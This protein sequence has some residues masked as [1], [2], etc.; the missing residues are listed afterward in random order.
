MASL[1]SEMLARRSPISSWYPPRQPAA[2]PIGSLSQDAVANQAQGP[3]LECHADKQR[4]GTLKTRRMSAPS[5]DVLLVQCHDDKSLV[6]RFAS[7]NII[8]ALGRLAGGHKKNCKYILDTEAA[9]RKERAC[10]IIA[11]LVFTVQRKAFYDPSFSF[12]ESVVMAMIYLDTLSQHLRKYEVGRSRWLCTTSLRVPT[13]N[14]FSANMSRETGMH[15]ISGKVKLPHSRLK[16]T[17]TVVEYPIDGWESYLT[18]RA[19]LQHSQ[20][21]SGETGG[22]NNPLPRGVMSS[23]SAYPHKG[24]W[25]VVNHWLRVLQDKSDYQRLT[26]GSESP[27]HVRLPEVNHW[28][29]VLLDMSDYQRLTIGSESCKTLLYT[30]GACSC[31]TNQSGAWEKLNVLWSLT[32]EQRGTH[33]TR[34]DINCPTVGCSR[35]LRQGDSTPYSC[36][37]VIISCQRSMQSMQSVHFAEL[38]ISR[39]LKKHSSNFGPASSAKIYTLASHQGEPALI[40]GRVTGYFQVGIVSDDAV[41]RWV[42]SGISRF[43]PPLHSGTAPY[44]LQ[45]PSSALKT[46]LLRAAQISSITMTH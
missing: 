17:Y 19:Y 37:L 35:N 23:A 38:A 44:S 24:P 36:A 45:S 7:R 4:M 10:F 39:D 20:R 6:R 9:V 31:P 40:P 29:R 15:W 25:A 16:F 33:Y 42:F 11:V 32:R 14:C 41:N 43:P 28:L 27:R 12:V 18:T 3:S 21:L 30:L 46:S 1:A 8:G 22:S 13:S 34:A 2:Q 5:L 26:I